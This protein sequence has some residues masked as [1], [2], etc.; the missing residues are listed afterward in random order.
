MLSVVL[1]PRC[2]G[3]TGSRHKARGLENGF[4]AVRTVDALMNKDVFNMC[5]RKV[6]TT[7]LRSI[8]NRVLST[9]IRTTRPRD[10]TGKAC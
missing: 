3:C 6:N 7:L 8:E 4:H 10:I 1:R 2:K 5:K 9:L